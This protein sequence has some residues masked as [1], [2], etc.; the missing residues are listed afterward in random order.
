MTYY[1]CQHYVL[2]ELVDPLTFKRFGD[3]AYEFLSPSLLWSIDGVWELLQRETGKRPV[4]TIND[5]KWGG[6]L[7]WCG[8][9]TSSC[10]VGSLYS[11]HRR[12][13]AMDLHVKEM[14]AEEVR[15]M[16]LN[17]QHIDYELKYITK[18]E[19]K[20]D[21]VPIS[22]VHISCENFDKG[23]EGIHLFDV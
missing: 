20:K 23:K 22:W 19:H 6:K 17:F 1:H 13:Q 11:P 8:L 10:F 21:G 12:G 16:I 5:W 7:E 18:M 2:E 14:K 15:K 3:R 4:I 9:R